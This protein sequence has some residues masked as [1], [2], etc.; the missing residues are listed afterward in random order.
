MG[1]HDELDEIVEEFDMYVDS[2]LALNAPPNWKKLTPCIT[3][4]T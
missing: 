3:L 1:A 2:Q 4:Q